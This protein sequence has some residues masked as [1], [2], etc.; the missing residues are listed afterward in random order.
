MTRK[1][2]GT[3]FPQRRKTS[4]GLNDD[5]KLNNKNILDRKSNK[6]HRASPGHPIPIQT[7]KAKKISQ[8]KYWFELE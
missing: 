8:I 4:I 1:S 5:L 6:M 2:T 3:Q 7:M